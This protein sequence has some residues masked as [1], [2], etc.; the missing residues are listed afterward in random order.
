MKRKE[1]RWIKK[2]GKERLSL[3]DDEQLTFELI[4]MSCSE[5][6]DGWYTSPECYK[7]E[8]ESREE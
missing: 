2:C 6:Y 8:K 7:W 5:M 3:Q 4:S 1:L